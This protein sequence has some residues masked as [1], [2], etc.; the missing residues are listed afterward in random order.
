MLCYVMLCYVMLCYVMLCYVMFYVM[1]CYVMLCYV[2]LC[3]VMLY[4]VMLC[5]LCML[6]YVMSCYVTLCYITLR[7]V[8]LCYATSCFDAIM[9]LYLR[10]NDIHLSSKSSQCDN[11]LLWF[12]MNPNPTTIYKYFCCTKTPTRMSKKRKNPM[13]TRRNNS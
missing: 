6:C 11:Q 9:R 13:L 5:M 10:H 2:M 4:Y 8:A 12:A 1:L 7:S 3:Y